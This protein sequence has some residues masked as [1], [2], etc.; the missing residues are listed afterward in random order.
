MKTDEQRI[1]YLLKQGDN[2]AYRH[3]YEHHYALLCAVAHEYLGD[4]FLSETLVDDL[5][6]HLWEKRATLDIAVSLRS[7]LVRAVRNRCCNYLQLAH[8]R[9]E[10]PFS[11]VSA[12]D[13]EYM[14]DSVSQDYPLAILLEN[15]LEEKVRRAIENLPDDCRRVFVKSRFEDRH[16]AQIAAELGISVHTVKYHI[17]QALARLKDDLA[18]YL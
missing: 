14:Q 3:V 12:T 9:R 10:V 18:D 7:Y 4:R 17:R 2:E 13:S 6:F 1:I 16:Y 11:S 8:E 5:I 15:E